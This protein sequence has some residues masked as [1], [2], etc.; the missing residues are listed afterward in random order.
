MKNQNSFCGVNC[1]SCPVFAATK[2][3]DNEYREKISR[4]WGLHYK[5][6]FTLKDINC[7][8]CK[9]EKIFKL[10]KFC[11][12][13]PCNIE[14]GIQSCSECDFY[15]C[16]RIER[17]QKSFEKNRDIFSIKKMKSKRILWI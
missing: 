5:R 13:K 2:N 15:P 6:E 7:H 12:I 10:C 4:E 1:E 8:G 14:K 9:S 3:D 16:E 11:D 17:F